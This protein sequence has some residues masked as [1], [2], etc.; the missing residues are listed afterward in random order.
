M[1]EKEENTFVIKA[2]IEKSRKENQLLR[3]ELEKYIAKTEVISIFNS[4]YLI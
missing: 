4:I 2:E 3:N 1:K